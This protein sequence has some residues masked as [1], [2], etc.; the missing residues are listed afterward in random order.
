M[1]DD[2]KLAF[3][4]CATVFAWLMVVAL[5]EPPNAPVAVPSRQATPSVTYW[6]PKAPGCSK[7]STADRL[8]CSRDHAIEWGLETR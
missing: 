1:S 7:G 6:Q 3:Y 8:K 5:Y 2:I 4:G